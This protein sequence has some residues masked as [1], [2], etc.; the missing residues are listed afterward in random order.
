MLYDPVDPF[1]AYRDDLPVVGTSWH[2]TLI[3]LAIR[4]APAGVPVRILVSNHRDGEVAARIAQKLGYGTV[5][6]SGG[7]NT[8]WVEKGA[9]AG[10]LGLR[11]SLAEGATVLLTAEAPRDGRERAGLGSVVLA[12]MTG[13]PLVGLGVAASRAIRVN[14]WDK[15]VVPLPFGRI[16]IVPTPL[17]RVPGRRQRRGDG[18]EAPRASG[19]VECRHRARLRDR[20]PAAWL[21]CRGRWPSPPTAVSPPSSRPRSRFLIARRVAAGKADAARTPERYGRASLPRPAGRVAWVHAASVGETLALVPLVARVI[22]AGFAV[23][24]TSGT[25]TSAAIAAERLPKGAVHQYA[26]LDVTRYVGR[27]LDHWR[28]DVAIVAEFGGV[29]GDASRARRGASVP[30][31]IVNG[32][33]SDRSF[34]RWHR[35]RAVAAPLFARLVAG[36]RPVGG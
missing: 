10:F 9:L 3:P 5:R 36:A 14:S 6:G 34:A 2:G 7:R 28:P 27:F 35:V 32:R 18:G 13:R 12:R 1:V 31:V 23:V 4:P 11:A 24:F 30:L 29:A 17:I 21:T 33:F 16:A 26:P 20:R 22:A 8:R 19:R 25:V 15:A